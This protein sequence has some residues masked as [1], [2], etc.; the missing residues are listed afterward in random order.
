MRHMVKKEYLVKQ[1]LRMPHSS[2]NHIRQEEEQLG[3]TEYTS[4][5]K[6]AAEMLNN[7]AEK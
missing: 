2:R 5:G 1:Q 6:K 3:E 4:W 7:F